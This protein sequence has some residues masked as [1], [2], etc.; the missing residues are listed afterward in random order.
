MISNMP[1]RL[2]AVL[3]AIT[4]STS[5]LLAQSGPAQAQG[6]PPLVALARAHVTITADGLFAIDN[7]A[8]ASERRTLSATFEP[9]N[10]ELR[11]VDRHLRLAAPPNSAKGPGLNAPMASI[12]GYIPRWAFEAFAWYVIIVGGTFATVGLFLDLT[13]FGLPAGAVL[14]AI[15]IGVGVTGSFLLWY[16]D[17]YMPP[18]GWYV[19]VF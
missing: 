11:S 2:I 15:G 17:N 3:L 12:C 16:V 9:L 14:G 7:R 18:E 13:I 5:S 10:A 1:R 6:G 19:C 4:F 8:S